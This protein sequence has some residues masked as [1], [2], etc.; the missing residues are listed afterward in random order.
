M[1]LEGLCHTHGNINILHTRVCFWVEVN[2]NMK[3]SL[4]HYCVG[5]TIFIDIRDTQNNNEN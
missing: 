5:R 4:L 1:Q 3:I 2:I